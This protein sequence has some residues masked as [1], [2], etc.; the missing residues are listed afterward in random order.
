MLKPEVHVVVGHPY[1]DIGKGWLSSCIGRSLG[2]DTSMIKIDPM[3]S[4]EFPRDLGVPIDGVVVTDDA[5][6]YQNQG[7]S[8]HP[9]QN[10]VLGGW[11]SNALHGGALKEG[12]LSGEV[13]K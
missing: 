13:Q 9:N 8:F 1:S 6:T 4:P 11:M 12:I 2:A 10:I 5:A 7:L 3:L